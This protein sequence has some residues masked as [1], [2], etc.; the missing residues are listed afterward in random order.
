[1]NVNV[2]PP[3]FSAS[4]WNLA[5]LPLALKM[6][7]LYGTWPGFLDLK[8]SPG[9]QNVHLSASMQPHARPFA[10]AWGNF[11]TV[12]LEAARPGQSFGLAGPM[13]GVFE[14]G[15][16]EQDDVPTQEP[17]AAVHSSAT[18]LAPF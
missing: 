14:A 9:S 17:L 11:L 10:E 2:Q 13:C 8:G 1:M 7:H 12:H 4:L 15:E 16:C 5:L 18:S 6:W 3:L